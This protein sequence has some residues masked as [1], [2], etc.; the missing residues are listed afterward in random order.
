MK[1][2]NLSN[3]ELIVINKQLELANQIVTKISHKDPHTPASDALRVFHKR[4]TSSL[5]TLQLICGYSKHN[6]HYDAVMIL[7]GMYDAMLQAMYIISVPSEVSKRAELYHDYIWIEKHSLLGRFDKSTT[8]FANLIKNSP[9]R[10]TNEKTI[11]EQFNRV[12]TKY[13]CKNGRVRSNW[14]PGKLDIIAKD[15]G[16]S[17]EYEL[18][19]HTLSKVVHS[20]PFGVKGNSIIKGPSALTMGFHFVFRCLGAIGKYQN[21]EFSQDES[22]V[23]DIAQ[24]CYFDAHI[25]PNE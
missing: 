3:E 2:I 10:A 25:S 9:M 14:Y 15:V 22:D 20:T 23:I 6:Y 12:K 7:R 1:P 24:R 17:D 19:Q 13:L 16:L 5:D 21:I 4:L 18:M 8:R 11:I